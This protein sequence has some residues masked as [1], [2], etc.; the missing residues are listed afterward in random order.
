MEHPIRKA[1]IHTYKR[2]DTNPDGPAWVA[3]FHPD[4]NCLLFFPGATEDEVVKEA[5]EYREMIIKKFEDAYIARKN[6]AKKRKKK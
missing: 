5:E 4:K 1:V 2:M 3:R 6:A